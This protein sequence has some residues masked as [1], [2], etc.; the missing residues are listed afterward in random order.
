M[1]TVLERIGKD[2]LDAHGKSILAIDMLRYDQFILFF[3]DV[4]N[5]TTREEVLAELTKDPVEWLLR[6][7]RHKKEIQVSHEEL[8]KALEE[9]NSEESKKKWAEFCQVCD[10]ARKLPDTPD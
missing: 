7:E 2:L 6:F 8:F 1:S 3:L 10:E 9:M 4:T 5:L